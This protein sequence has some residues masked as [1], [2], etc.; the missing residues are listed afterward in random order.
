MILELRFDEAF[1][2]TIR[3]TLTGAKAAR[4]G[5][6]RN[7]A[8]APYRSENSMVQISTDTLVASGDARDI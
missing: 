2:M 7:A 5:Q 8:G 4:W 1:Y 6:Y 3:Q